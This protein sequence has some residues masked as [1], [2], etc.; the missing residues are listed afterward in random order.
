MHVTVSPPR[1]LAL[2]V[3]FGAAACGAGVDPE[4]LVGARLPAETECTKDPATLAGL[5]T[6]PVA[7]SLDDDCPT[8][9]HCDDLT[10]TCSLAC[11][12]A[13]ACTA[14]GTVCDC[15]G[16]CVAASGSTLPS[17]VPTL[18]VGATAI[19]LTGAT[20]EVSTTIT[21]STTTA[22]LTDA[23]AKKPLV[24]V[25]TTQ[26]VEV[27]CD[28][29]TWGPACTMGEWSYVAPGIP[30]GPYVATRTLRVRRTAAADASMDLRVIV[31]AEDV[32]NP[33][34][35]LPVAV[36]A[37]SPTGTATT[38]DGEWRG[39]LTV[40]AGSQAAVTGVHP[41]VNVV[42]A[43]YGANCWASADVTE[44]VQSACTGKSQC[45]YT[46]DY[47][48]IGDP[49]PGCHKDFRV[50]YTCGAQPEPRVAFFPGEAGFRSVVGIGCDDVR[51]ITGGLLEPT[52]KVSAVGRGDKLLVVDD[53]RSVAASGR[54][55]VG[56][57]PF[58]TAYV[59]R[60]L[61]A[62]PARPGS[63]EANSGAV[64]ATVVSEGLTWS[65][66]RDRER[67]AGTVVITLPQPSRP[68]RVRLELT[69]VKTAAPPTCAA[70]CAT[71][72]TCDTR[73]DACVAGTAPA[74]GHLPGSTLTSTKASKWYDATVNQ[75]LTLGSNPLTWVTSSPYAKWM[76]H[77]Y[78]GA[79]PR[80]AVAGIGHRR[81]YYNY[82]YLEYGDPFSY[83]PYTSDFGINV[84]ADSFLPA[85]S[86]L[87]DWY[88]PVTREGTFLCP[89]PHDGLPMT[90]VDPSCGSDNNCLLADYRQDVCEKLYHVMDVSFS[91]GFGRCTVAHPAPSKG[92]ELRNGYMPCLHDYSG[93]LDTLGHHAE[94][95]CSKLYE[96][97]VEGREGAPSF[98][99]YLA[100][101][102]RL[103]DE[104]YKTGGGATLNIF[105]CPAHDVIFGDETGDRAA[106]HLACYD[107]TI[108]SWDV[109]LSSDLG[110][111]QLTESN[112]DLVCRNGRL[113]QTVNI[114]YLAERVKRGAPHLTGTQLADA[115]KA[116]L[117]R[118]PPAAGTGMRDFFAP[119]LCV[120]LP[121]LL[122]G[123][124]EAAAR[125]RTYFLRLVQQW[126]QV[127]DR[128]ALETV[129]RW[130]YDRTFYGVDGDVRSLPLTDE[131]ETVLDQ[132]ERRWDLVLDP[133][134]TAGLAAVPDATLAAID[135]RAARMGGKALVSAPSDDAARGLPVALLEGATAHLR[136]LETYLDEARWAAYG[137]CSAGRTSVLSE[138]VRERAGTTLRYVLAVRTLAA[139]LEVRAAAAAGPMHGFRGAYV[140]AARELAALESKLTASAAGYSVCQN[141]LGVDDRGIPLVFGDVTGDVGLFF[142]LSSYLLGKADE[143]LDRAQKSVEAARIGWRESF[144]SKVADLVADPNGRLLAIKEKYGHELIALCGITG[145][146]ARD[147]LDA[148]KSN[149]IKIESCHVAKQGPECPD[150]RHHSCYGGEIGESV[151]AF[152]AALQEVEVGRTEHAV[153]IET[154][155][156]RVSYC[157]AQ[158]AHLDVDNQL[159]AQH[160]K[161]MRELRKDQGLFASIGRWFKTALACVGAVVSLGAGAPA[162]AASA[163]DSAL[164]ESSQGTEEKLKRTEENYAALKQRRESQLM[165]AACFHE[166]DVA[167]TGIKT[168]N[169]QIVRRSI[170]AQ[171]V[172]LKLQNQRQRVAQLVN[173]GLAALAR[174]EGRMVPPVTF[175][176][177]TDAKATTFQ[178]DLLWAKTVVYLALQAAEYELQTKIDL[179]G[180]SGSLRARIVKAHTVA[181]LEEAREIIA[182]ELFANGYN[183]RAPRQMATL[184]SLREQA[185]AVADR[186]GR[187]LP[188]TPPRTPAERF[189]RRLLSPQ[190][191][192]Y[193]GSGV[194][195]GQGIEFT[196]APQG[197]LSA[198]CAERISR[199][200]VDL[201][202]T[203]G[204]FNW[205]A[206]R[207]AAPVL[208]YKRNTAGS[209]WCQD[210]THPDRMRRP[211]QVSSVLP[212]RYLLGHRVPPGNAA[213]AAAFTA[214]Q[215]SA[216]LPRPA[217]DPFYNDEVYGIGSPELQS[218]GVYGD[219]VLVLPWRGLLEYGFR[220]ANL[221]DIVIRFETVSVS[222]A[223]SLP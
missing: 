19:D 25:L 16:R 12:P 49:A 58:G 21:L 82:G 115:C 163:I 148:F 126:V 34:L 172:M 24:R 196:L 43:R 77:K 46:I 149:F 69:R 88:N 103:A 78:E 206:N 6:S 7:C 171:A 92:D 61:T 218:R 70:G 53:S 202:G 86:G 83:W 178:R 216:T 4:P 189:V 14:P 130:Q 128:F 191:A 179:W 99:S 37:A 109:A 56:G 185:L 75:F 89:A 120:S 212:R 73:I 158:Q 76:Y 144:M 199:V 65:S 145:F 168:V 20:S 175:H 10:R 190:A 136:A 181:E 214:A 165:S 184:V 205:P 68:I 132:L 97:A 87:A 63:G 64:D 127:N 33:R 44:A 138:A 22:S 108:E 95:R 28:G 15:T 27:S 93:T 8:G 135:H 30:D 142:R 112:R 96:R 9:S 182:T 47:T 222:N 118:D 215:L 26:H 161:T 217:T 195:V 84:C 170:D 131:L 79:F 48:V 105:L 102:C 55:L 45:A 40:A 66:E 164:D 59:E 160:H 186:S 157:R 5:A 124:L 155:D 101:T 211:L 194:Y 106:E 213:D 29:T 193:D 18:A 151:L 62:R 134:V 111:N 54:L 117:L 31:G 152:H 162:C 17:V 150:P 125:P 200:A 107:P 32:V 35:E 81:A 119:T 11:G 154:F 67:V 177:W 197:N 169:A 147:V 176:F 104:V 100:S 133:R 137:D 113:P 42:S 36:G 114:D 94:L 52:V 39:S 220:L 223:P 219:Y 140:D 183:G 121:R 116:E 1:A 122:P 188:G 13:N 173:D 71:G 141:P 123:I 180:P 129:R 2:V 221:T 210:A 51:P 209:Q 207:G 156:K 159:L 57:Q 91:F 201:Q 167:F 23:T 38:L 60:W 50:T 198:R 98:D 3:A 143:G 72:T 208:I 139:S 204:Q 80:D 90:T 174:E 74:I 192:V 166:A 41:T 146:L 153:L 203:Q 187:A 85:L 110:N